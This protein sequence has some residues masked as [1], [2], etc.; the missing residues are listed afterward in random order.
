MRIALLFAL[1]ICNYSCTNDVNFIECTME[2]FTGDSINGRIDGNYFRES[3]F[4]N[5]KLLSKDF[6]RSGQISIKISSDNPF[7]LTYIIPEVKEKEHF[8]FSVWEYGATN[9]G[10]LVVRS[11]NPNDFYIQQRK[12]KKVEKSKW[13]LIT[14]DVYVNELA[15]K[16]NLLVYLWNDNPAI[17]L[18]ISIPSPL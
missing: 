15:S 3:K 1:L 4:P 8:R 7:A 10:N 14:F 11:D 5:V 16:K 12:S 17:D 18:T 9:Y 13:E 6:S 2:S